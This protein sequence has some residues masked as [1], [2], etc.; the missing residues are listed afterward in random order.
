M[1]SRSLIVALALLL[2]LGATAAVFMYVNGVREDAKTGGALKPVIVAS[3]DVQAGTDLNPLIDGDV[4][5][6]QYVPADAVVS[7]AVTQISQLR[8]RTTTAAILANEQIPNSRLSGGSAL[9]GGTLGISPGHV[10]VTFQFDGP[11][12]GAGTIQRGDQLMIFATFQD[13]TVL[14]NGNLR[15]ILKRATTAGAQ[16]Q[17]QT[18]IGDF[19]V[20]LVPQVRVLGVT[21]PQVGDREGNVT[22]TLDLL[23]EDAANLVFAQQ[24]G[25]M[26][27]GL[28]PPNGQGQE[29]PAVSYPIDLLLGKVKKS[30]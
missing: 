13:V 21:N 12:G 14:G 20:T 30:A 28:L 17:P 8:G 11:S 1:R 26:W 23:P 27:T 19:T 6:T 7:G 5:R 15:D 4:F 18:Q 10:A 29:L 24:N 25:Q 9:P 2:A 22:L 3:Q 16:A